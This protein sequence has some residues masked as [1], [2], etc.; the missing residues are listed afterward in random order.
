MIARLFGRLL[1]GVHAGEGKLIW[2]QPAV[3]SAPPT[4]VL[5]SS[6][7]PEGAAMPASF[8]AKAIGGDNQSPPLEW[9]N[10]PPG[11]A[12]LALVMEDPDAP[13]P[14]TS[15]HL[16]VTGISP[17]ITGLPMGSL[18]RETHS[19]HFCLGKGLLG[20]RGYFGPMPPPAHGPHRYVFQIFALDRGLRA[21][22][23]YDR[24]AL[25]GEISGKVLARGKLIGTFERT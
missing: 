14:V 15:M 17:R 9:S 5:S 8:A 21:S 11:A 6:A 2:N 4:I 24:K 23:V 18:N 7:F 25:L 12:E 3:R 22:T 13:M 1:R 20:R 16:I 10:L 19:P